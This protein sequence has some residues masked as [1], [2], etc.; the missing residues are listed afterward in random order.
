[1]NQIFF[2]HGHILCATTRNP[3]S[4]FRLIVSS[5]STP[6]LSYIT[7]PA[8][9]CIV[10]RRH[11]QLQWIRGPCF[12]NFQVHIPLMRTWL[13][14]WDF[15]HPLWTEGS[16]SHQCTVHVTTLNSFASLKVFIW[17][18]CHWKW[19]WYTLKV[20]L[21]PKLKWVLL[22]IKHERINLQHCRLINLMHANVS[23]SWLTFWR[24]MLIWGVLFCSLFERE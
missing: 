14:V 11:W 15:R 1:M 20:V 24:G 13:E 21:L 9:R 12:L 10:P 5:G 7:L 16:V 22:K 3:L 8:G 2:W 19:W 17:Q 6:A 18:I 4:N 23:K